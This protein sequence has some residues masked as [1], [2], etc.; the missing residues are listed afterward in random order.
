MVAFGLWLF[1]RGEPQT[2]T[3][4][5][6]PQF[7]RAS[8]VLEAVKIAAPDLDVFLQ[9][10]D[11]RGTLR[12]VG[13]KPDV[14]AVETYM[15]LLDVRPRYTKLRILIDSPADK[16]QRK[17]VCDVPNNGAWSME[18]ENLDLSL[19]IRVHVNDNLSRTLTIDSRCRGARDL[20]TVTTSYN[21]AACVR[22]G[23]AALNALELS[24]K[25]PLASRRF[26]EADVKTVPIVWI[27][28]TDMESDQTWGEPKEFAPP[29]GITSL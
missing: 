10:D 11:Q 2:E 7:I 22:P 1:A 5:I 14:E 18:D 3:K 13:A 20:S 12:V 15:V 24:K 26:A 6:K 21:G 4:V 19:K 17:V 8:R 28:P 16:M 29:K 23:Y 27:E 9:A 25:S